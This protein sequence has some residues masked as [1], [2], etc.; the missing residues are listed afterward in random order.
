MPF[1]RRMYKTAT[2]NM[3]R[4]IRTVKTTTMIGMKINSMVEKPWVS[5]PVRGV[6]GACGA[7]LGYWPWNCC[8]PTP[9]WTGVDMADAG[10]E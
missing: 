6:D 10:L 9:I 3:T 4:P 5:W 1:L 2:R 8:L 7:V